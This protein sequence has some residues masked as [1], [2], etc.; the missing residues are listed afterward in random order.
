MLSYQINE[1]KNCESIWEAYHQINTELD[2]IGKTH[3]NKT[4]FVSSKILSKRKLKNLIY[5]KYILENLMFTPSY[6][7]NIS[8]KDIISKIKT[9]LS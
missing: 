8:Y 4:V 9:Y 3:Y 1:C 2:K 6:Y 5:Y 7:T